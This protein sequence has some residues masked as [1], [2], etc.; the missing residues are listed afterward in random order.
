VRRYLGEQGQPRADMIY[1]VAAAE[2]LSDTPTIL[3]PADATRRRPVRPSVPFRDLLAPVLRQGR[4]VQP[5]PTLAESRAFARQEVS[6]LDASVR[7]FLNPHIYPVGLEQS[8]HEFR[9]QL[10]L[11]K[12]PVRPA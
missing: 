11:A 12:R 3:D 10:M 9:T 6:S 1:N 7:R 2:P 4:L 5:L 8:L